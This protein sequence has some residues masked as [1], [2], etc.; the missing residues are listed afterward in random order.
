ML[1]DVRPTQFSQTTNNIEVLETQTNNLGFFNIPTPT[2]EVSVGDWE[3][4]ATRVLRENSEL[5]EK[6]AKL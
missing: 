4:V 3:A 6:L 2:I 5:W 1:Y